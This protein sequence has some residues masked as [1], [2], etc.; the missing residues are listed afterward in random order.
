MTVTTDMTLPAEL[1]EM[2]EKARAVL[3]A[4]AAYDAAAA[5]DT[6][7]VEAYTRALKQLAGAANAEAILKLYAWANDRVASRG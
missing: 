7:A 5:T 6:A 3:S 4:R 2:A 1:E